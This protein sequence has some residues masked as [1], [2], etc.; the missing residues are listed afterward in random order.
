[1]GPRPDLRGMSHNV[2]NALSVVYR[3][4]RCAALPH[5]WGLA[6]TTVA[7][8]VLIAVSASQQPVQLVEWMLLH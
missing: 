3:D 1:M 4:G 5:V 8:W 7:P 2:V 6:R